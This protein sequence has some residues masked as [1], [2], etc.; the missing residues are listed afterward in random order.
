MSGTDLVT[1]PPLQVYDVA[2]RAIAE[3]SNFVDVQDIVDKTAAAQ[4]YFR[5]AKNRTLEIQC[6][7]L[8]IRAERRYGQLLLELKAGGGLKEGRP[9]NGTDTEPFSQP[10]SLEDIGAD[11]KLSSRAQ[12][13]AQVPEERFETMADA[14]R[15]RLEREHD[16]VSATSLRE[17]IQAP[18]REKSRAEY[19]SRLLIG[20]QL[21]DLQSLA[22]S[23]FKAGAVLIDWPWKFEARGEN[24]YDRSAQRH[25]RT[26][27]LA[28]AH[29]LAPVLKELYAADVAVFFWMVDWQPREALEI[30]EVL[31]VEHKTTAFTWVKTN[32]EDALDKVIRDQSAWFM[33]QGYWTRANP[34][35]CWLATR[36][37]PS[38]MNADVRQA[39]FA[40][41]MEHSR[42]PDEVHDRIERL[43]DGPYLEIF[44][45]RPRIG[46]TVWGN[47]LPRA[48][49]LNSFLGDDVDRVTGE[50]SPAAA[51]DDIAARVA[52]MD[53]EGPVPCQP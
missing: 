44:G 1:I 52:A 46:W 25:Y 22:R 15:D 45:R 6:A 10:V 35:D 14:W 18:A 26:E 24:G 5:R 48:D 12:K 9:R 29:R 23:G 7:E 40:P 16:R 37:S 39:I 19:E 42:K 11:K 20:C 30:L 2:C 32:S 31:G 4:E 47:E 53:T 27:G 28:L 3:A 34:E 17:A 51:A 41:I 49:F 50:I 43:V 38:R 33:G 8:R 21:E 13:L 36:G